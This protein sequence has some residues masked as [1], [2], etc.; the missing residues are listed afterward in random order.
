MT[1]VTPR[2][3]TKPLTISLPPQL[4]AKAD[5]LQKETGKTRSEVFREALTRHFAFLEYQSLLSYSRQQAAKLGIRPTHLLYE[6]LQD[7]AL[8]NIS[9]PFEDAASLIQALK[10]K[11]K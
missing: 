6:A 5:A 7:T 9:G 1:K 10:K 2:R 3:T 11:Q 8:G 4:V